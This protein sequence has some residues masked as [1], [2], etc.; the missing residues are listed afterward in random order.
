MNPNIV[1]VVMDTTRARGRGSFDVTEAL[2]DI[3]PLSDATS[4]TNAFSSSPWT[5][6]SHASLFTGTTPSKHG[7]HA[8]H[9]YL[10]DTLPILPEILEENGYETVGVSNNTWISGEFGFERG[11]ESFYRTWQFVQTDTDLGGI[12]R[13]THGA[14]MFRKAGRRMFDGN[15]VTNVMN[16]VYGRY[17]R[18]RH[19]DGAARTNKWIDHW[20]S[21]RSDD[22]PFFLFVNYLEPHLDYR[23]PK[24]YAV[25]HLPDDVSLAEAMDVPQDAWRYIAGDLELTEQELSVLRGL[26]QAEIAYLCDKIEELI[27][28]F[29]AAGAWENTLFVLTSDHG[30]HIGEHGLMDHQYALYDTLLQVPLLVRG[31]T[32]SRE[33]EDELVHLKDIS[34]TILDILDVNIPKNLQGKSFHPAQQYSRE[35]VFGEYIAPIPT[36]EH[37]AS[38]LGELPKR[39]ERFDR[40]LRSVR[41]DEYKYIRGSD[42]SQELYEI[43]EDPFETDDIAKTSPQIVERMDTALDEWL[44]TFECAEARGDVSMSATTE[45]RLKEL[46]YLQ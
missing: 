6:P 36:L 40:S 46:G 26:Y 4:F 23:P 30:E 18:R 2:R 13:L 24:E 8:D 16:A 32:F 11:F 1:L 39:V 43:Q 41:S 19:D 33:A 25:E 14:E 44:S 17:L 27:A 3:P 9:R 31:S 21:G 12:A 22:R 28:S 38:K 29:Q 37:L 7:A 20:L 35:F 42:G 34:A 5:L 15:P 45:S 10:D